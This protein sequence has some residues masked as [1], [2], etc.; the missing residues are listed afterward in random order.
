MPKNAKRFLCVAQNRKR[1][2][3]LYL[4][5]NMDNIIL[6]RMP[7]FNEK[8]EP[9]LMMDF[10]ACGVNTL[11]GLASGGNG[12]KIYLV[13]PDKSDD[14]DD[15]TTYVKEV[16]RLIAKVK[17]EQVAKSIAKIKNV[18]SQHKC[19]AL[20]EGA[21]YAG[22]AGCGGIG[23]MYASAGN[24]LGMVYVGLAGVFGLANVAW[25]VPIRRRAKRTLEAL[26]AW[27]GEQENRLVALE[28]LSDQ[29]DTY[30]DSAKRTLVTAKVEVVY[31]P[32]VDE[33]VNQQM[34]KNPLD[35][36][37]F[38]TR[39]NQGYTHAAQEAGIA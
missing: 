37:I 24:L 17:K 27:S 3:F 2:I 18:K 14:A 16:I 10:A 1:F 32:L 29:I 21:V 12:E 33:L 39:L 28:G 25:S 36:R 9:A 35:A 20:I 34:G 19:Y 13:T 38:I 30:L 5:V 8:L 23:C 11:V 31:A 4:V 26:M 22:A 6:K 15:V 7:T